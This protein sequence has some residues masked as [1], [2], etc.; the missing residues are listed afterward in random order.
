MKLK[1]WGTRGSIPIAGKNFN[2]YGGETSCYEVISNQGTSVVLDAGTGFRK[3]GKQLLADKKNEIYLIFSHFHWD[4]IMGFPFF[5]LLYLP[6]SIL[7]LF[8]VFNID[9]GVDDMFRKAMSAPNF[10]LEFREL[11]SQMNIYD[12][13]L[14]DLKIDDL[15]FD[16]IALNHPNNGQ[17][18]KIIENKKSLVYITDNELGIEYATGSSFEEFKDFCKDADVLLHDSEFTEEDY[19]TKKGWG[20]SYYLDALNLAIKANVKKFILIHHN[21]DR[22][23]AEIDAMVEDCIRVAK[24]QNSSVKIEAAY[25][26]MTIEV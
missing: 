14:E 25:E 17:G 13:K 11:K 6:N 20:H 24:E 12:T 22:K 19:K 10:P 2:K 3:L 4:H 15:T 16:K 5:P 7:H 21:Q 9:I 26:G 18:V 23:D 8:S 1:V